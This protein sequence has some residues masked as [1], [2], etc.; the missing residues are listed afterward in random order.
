M[1]PEELRRIERDVA[2]Q[3]SEP[4]GPCIVSRAYCASCG[5]SDIVAAVPLWRRSRR[6]RPVARRDVTGANCPAC[7]ARGAIRPLELP[8]PIFLG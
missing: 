7:K 8:R 4:G 3:G 1:D 2:R 6:R 5:A